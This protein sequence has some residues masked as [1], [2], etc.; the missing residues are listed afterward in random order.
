MVEFVEKFKDPPSIPNKPDMALAL[1]GIYVF[2]TRFLIEQLQRDA[3]TE[4]SNR[5]FGKDIIPYIVKNDTA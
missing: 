3:A 2:E 5:D 1:M 4:G